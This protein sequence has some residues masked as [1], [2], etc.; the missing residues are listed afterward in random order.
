MQ[1]RLRMLRLVAINATMIQR[2]Y[3]RRRRR[4]GRTLKGNSDTA[5]TLELSKIAI[6]SISIRIKMDID[7][8][9]VM[10]L[11]G[12]DE[13]VSCDGTIQ[14]GCNCRNELIAA[15]RSK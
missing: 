8:E 1:Q 6:V 2:P 7:E 4:R 11:K 5:L 9:T 3:R 15:E 10:I 13:E 12:G 14:L